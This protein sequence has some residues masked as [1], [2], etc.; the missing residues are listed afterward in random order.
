[1]PQPIAALADSPIPPSSADPVVLEPSDPLEEAEALKSAL[2]E[3]CN[4]VGRLAAAL[5]ARGK[6]RRTVR[7]VMDPLRR[8][9]GQL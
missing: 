1:M 6:D 3:V 5:R 4:R 8:L 9:A 7:T 2:A